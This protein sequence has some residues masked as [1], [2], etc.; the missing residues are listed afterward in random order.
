MD[1][2]PHSRWRLTR[3]QVLW[4]SCTIV[5]LVMFTSLIGGYI[6]EWKWTGIIAHNDFPKRTLWDWLQLLIIPAVLAGGGIWF[7]RRQQA[8]SQQSEDQRAQDG[9]LQAYIDHISELLADKDRPLHRARRGD[10][11]SA[12]ARARTL[13][14]LARLDGA[15]KGSVLQFLYESGLITRRH[16]VIDLSGANLRGADLR[17]A[18]LVGGLLENLSYLSGY[19]P[20][21]SARHEAANLHFTDLREA[22]LSGAN[23]A[24]VNLRGANLRKANLVGTQLVDAYLR[25][26][27]LCEADLTSANLSKAYLGKADLTSAKLTKADLTDA[28]LSEAIMPDGAKHPYQRSTYQEKGHGANGETSGL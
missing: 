27:Q 3:S 26:A 7:N 23:L 4:T 10:Q 6:F 5:A 1:K 20:R 8:R 25:G 24:T 2:Q 18:N 17:K 22:D 15:R 11:L 12:L 28:N 13:T 9:A 19:I 14:V 16:V 21:A